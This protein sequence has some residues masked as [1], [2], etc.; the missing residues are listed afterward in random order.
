VRR[1]EENMKK[2][3]EIIYEASPLEVLT[4]KRLELQRFQET[5][6]YVVDLL[7]RNWEEIKE[8]IENNDEEKLGELRKE[9]VNVPRTNH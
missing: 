7:E 8:T 2:E 4:R 5:G 9:L 6:V 3:H 1:I